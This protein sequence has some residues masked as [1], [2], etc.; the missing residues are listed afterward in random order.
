MRFR[1]D[2]RYDTSLPN[3]AVRYVYNTPVPFVGFNRADQGQI[4]TLRGLQPPRATGYYGLYVQ[5]ER[6]M[7]S[8]GGNLGT[9]DSAGASTR[10]PASAVSLGRENPAKSL[11]VKVDSKQNTGFNW[12]GFDRNSKVEVSQF[13]VRETPVTDFFFAARPNA[14]FTL[15]AGL[16][17]PLVRTAPPGD[18][19]TVIP[20]SPR[21]VPEPTGFFGLTEVRPLPVVPGET[22][23]RAAGSR[24]RDP[25]PP[26]GAVTIDDG[27]APRGTSSAADLGRGSG[28]QGAAA[29][30]FEPRRGPIASDGDLPSHADRDYFGR[31]IFD[32]IEATAAVPAP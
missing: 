15:L 4:G 3:N 27:E 29:D 10:V 6:G 24:I 18:G 9:L 14:P 16:N 19:P 30:V 26:D 23:L 1:G 7:V 17:L 5:V 32:Y 25:R 22:L 28:A 13:L 11:W 20:P 31:G 12:I 2:V 8:F 21:D